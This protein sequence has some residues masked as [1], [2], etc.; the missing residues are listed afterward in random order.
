MYV[1]LEVKY[2]GWNRHNSNELQVGGKCLI[3]AKDIDDQ[4]RNNN[5][6]KSDS[7]NNARSVQQKSKQENS[8][9]TGYIQKMSKIEEPVV[10]FVEEKGMKYSVPYI[11]LKPFPLVRK[12][13]QNTLTSHNKK[14]TV[15]DGWFVKLFNLDIIVFI[16]LSSISILYFII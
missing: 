4:D 8:Y 2:A 14:N 5:S 16:R 13:R 12:N 6:S 9:Y 1:V 15:T 3:N 10:V 11:A 7:E